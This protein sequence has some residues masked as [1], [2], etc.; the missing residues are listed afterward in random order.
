MA[1]DRKVKDFLEVI[2]A[3]WVL[4]LNFTEVHTLEELK[5]DLLLSFLVFGDVM[6]G[7]CSHALAAFL[8]RLFQ[9]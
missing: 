3:G 8:R 4:F 5:V 7:V 9:T 2:L 1:W 6:H